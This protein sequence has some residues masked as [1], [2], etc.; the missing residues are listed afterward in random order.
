MN[1]Q[2]NVVQRQPVGTTYRS[3][4]SS[5]IDSTMQQPGFILDGSN[6]IHNVLHVKGN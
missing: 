5:S 6:A 4:E 2:S 1:M 3:F